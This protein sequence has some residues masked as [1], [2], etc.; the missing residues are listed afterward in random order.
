MS[1]RAGYS[2]QPTPT[3]PLAHSCQQNWPEK[4]SVSGAFD[5][6][7]AGLG[8]A[9]SGGFLGGGALRKQVVGEISAGDL[10]RWTVPCEADADASI[11]DLM[12]VDAEEIRDFFGDGIFPHDAWQGEE[13]SDLDREEADRQVVDYLPE[14]WAK[15]LEGMPEKKRAEREEAIL[16]EVD[17]DGLRL[18]MAAPEEIV[19]MAE[20][21]AWQYRESHPTTDK[22]GNAINRDP[23]HMRRRTDKWWRKK[24]ARDQKDA[25][26]Y[27][28]AALG[29]VG[30]KS[31]PGRPLYAS[32]HSVEV[33]DRHQL[34]TTTILGKLYLICKDDPNIKIPMIEIDKR[35]R[36]AKAAEIRTLI[37]MLL[38][39]WNALGWYV[40]WITVT[41]PGRYVCYSTNEENRVEEYDLKLGPKQAMAAIQDDHHRVLA[42]LRERG[43]RPSGWWNAQPQQ[44]GTPHRHYILAVPTVEDARQV[45]DVFRDKFSSRKNE[46]NGPDRGCAAYVIGDDDPKYKPRTGKNGREETPKTAAKYAARYSARL[47][48]ESEAGDEE[49]NGGGNGGAGGAGGDVG[50]TADPGAEK[51]AA[52]WK[53]YAAWKWL[54]GLRTMGWLGF[55]SQRSP[56]DLWRT[57]WNAAQRAEDDPSDPRMALAM[58]LMREAKNWTEAAVQARADAKQF[59]AGDPDAVAALDEAN[60]A[61]DSA[62]RSAWHAALAV[63]MWPDTDIDPVEWAWLQDEL[64]D[65]ADALPPMPYREDKK[66]DY[67]EIRQVIRGAISVSEKARLVR[68]GDPIAPLFDAVLA[69]R[70]AGATIKPP[71]GKLTMKHIGIALRKAGI[72]A[73]ARPGGSIA[74]YQCDGEIVLKTDKKW[75]IVDEKKAQ[76]MQDKAAGELGSY[77][78]RKARVAE[79]EKRA[80]AKVRAIIDRNKITKDSV[81]KCQAA[82]QQKCES[83]EIPATVRSWMS[84]AKK[85]LGVV[86]DKRLLDYLSV[87]PTYPSNRPSASL[88]GDGRPPGWSENGTG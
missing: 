33:F 35:A 7:T 45:C 18:L 34:M 42:V 83:G 27:V 39:R 57:H 44:S 71:S 79:T 43:I 11:V 67:G 47:E 46:E 69:A 85:T 52:E 61:S 20:T 37:D 55:D 76:E 32:N 60:E 88:G 21:R 77:E 22:D 63:G 84:F 87:S 58:R 16:R 51:K 65:D 73:L 25:L 86:V 54:R 23:H 10:S 78:T 2:T 29:M 70:E 62:A 41:L 81:F 24:L 3:L 66:N 31:L 40:C 72:K 1:L 38:H 13:W 28:E 64:K 19:A 6:V 17:W 36:K 74:L 48:E 82:F 15:A 14:D 4:P 8:L 56:V 5:A 80:F 53:R 26:M 68:G 30:G 59:P 75:A 12:E 49:G 9:A 50:G